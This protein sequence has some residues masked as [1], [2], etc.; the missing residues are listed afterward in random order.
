MQRTFLFW[1]FMLVVT[2]AV[3]IPQVVNGQ[4]GSPRGM[5][6]NPGMGNGSDARTI[7]QLLSYHDQIHRTVEEIPGGIQAV[8]E[9]DNPQVVAL[10]QT[11]VSRMYDRVSRKQTVPMIGMSPTLPKMIQVK[12]QY[13]RQLQ[14]IPKG[15]AVTETANSPEIIAMIREHAREVTQFAEQGMPAMIGGKMR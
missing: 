6:G 9:S 15:I 3:V 12:N 14:L 13:Q 5:M 1:L 10:I 2:V 7:H 11:H 4:M 8:T